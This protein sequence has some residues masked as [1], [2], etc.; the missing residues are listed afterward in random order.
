MKRLRIRAMSRQKSKRDIN[1]VTTRATSE[2]RDRLKTLC[3]KYGLGGPSNFFRQCIDKFFEADEADD[4]ALPIDL[5]RKHHQAFNEREAKLPRR[6][7][8]VAK[9][10][11]RKKK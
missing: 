8:P 4:L 7:S 6:R 3:K 9:L 2:E 1:L 11:S 5:K 10:P